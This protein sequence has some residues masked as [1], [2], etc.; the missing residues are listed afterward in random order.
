MVFTFMFV[1]EY[2]MLGTT[3]LFAQVMPFVVRFL[4]YD[5]SLLHNVI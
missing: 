3:Q 5:Y 4:F 1:N 2:K